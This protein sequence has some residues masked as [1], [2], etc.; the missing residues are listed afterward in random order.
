MNELDTH[1]K[2]TSDF[3]KIG[4]VTERDFFR[5]DISRISSE[6]PPLVRKR[7]RTRGGVRYRKHAFSRNRQNTPKIFRAFGAILLLFF[8]VFRSIFR[9]FNTRNDRFSSCIS[10]FSR[11]RRIFLTKYFCLQAFCACVESAVAARE[12]N[13]ITFLPRPNHTL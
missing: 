9:V 11:L 13:M 2:K 5:E 7:S 3:L 1:L 6:T 10:K 4:S 8:T 12:S